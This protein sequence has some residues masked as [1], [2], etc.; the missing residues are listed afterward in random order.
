MRR[1]FQTLAVLVFKPGIRPNDIR[2][3]VSVH[4][5][6]PV[7]CNRPVNAEPNVM[8]LPRL[9]GVGRNFNQQSALSF[10]LASPMITMSG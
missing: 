2:V 5:Q 4:V 6:H 9:C 7:W 10:V 3:T 1:P 8:T